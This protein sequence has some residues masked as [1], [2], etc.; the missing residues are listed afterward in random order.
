MSE[1]RSNKGTNSEV[2]DDFSLIPRVLVLQDNQAQ[3][4]RGTFN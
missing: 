1:Q 2:H 3:K 4:N